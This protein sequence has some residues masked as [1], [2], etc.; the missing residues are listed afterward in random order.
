M[1]LVQVLFVVL[2]LVR[3]KSILMKL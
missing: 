2:K 3:L 1:S